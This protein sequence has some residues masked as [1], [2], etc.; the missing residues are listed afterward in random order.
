MQ[1]HDGPKIVGMG[2]DTEKH[3][4]QEHTVRDISPESIGEETSKSPK[5]DDKV[6]EKPR[7]EVSFAVNFELYKLKNYYFS[8]LSF[9]S[10]SIQ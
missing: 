1:A 4:L 6:E 5:E 8:F 7:V 9:S 2:E 10:I 3:I